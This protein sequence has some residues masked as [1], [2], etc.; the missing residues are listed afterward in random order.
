MAMTQNSTA[1]YDIYGENSAGNAQY[2]TFSLN[3]E[4]Y[5]VDIL[6]VVEVKVWE[7]VT[8]LPDTPNCVKG[9]LNL[10]GTVVPIID[11]RA[12]YEIESIEYTA[13]TV[14][15]VLKVDVAGKEQ[16]IGLVVDAV[17]DVMNINQAQIHG[18]SE[19]DMISRR[20]D[21]ITG[22]ATLDNKNIILLDASKI[23]TE[24]QL[25]DLVKQY[26]M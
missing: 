19:F 21:S 9:V 1:A 20:T 23:L 10:R 26:P 2:F 25:G 18:A 15:L 3:G 6:S 11:L 13:A 14:I 24:S 16:T 4:E 5:G 22:V 8:V 12:Y 7:E 17:S